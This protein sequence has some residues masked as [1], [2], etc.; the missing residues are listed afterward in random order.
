MGNTLAPPPP[1]PFAVMV[2]LRAG[3]AQQECIC[4]MVLHRL[5]TIPFNN[6]A[7]R[8]RCKGE[9]RTA[10]QIIADH[11]TRLA[12]IEGSL[13][14]RSNDLKITIASDAPVLPQERP[15][16]EPLSAADHPTSMQHV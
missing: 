5:E 12:T 4:S 1:D 9:F 3:I 16:I 15:P 14:Q 10:V 11:E 2:A 13:A 6:N 7:D 8:E